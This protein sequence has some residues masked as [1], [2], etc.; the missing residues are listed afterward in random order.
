MGKAPPLFT[1]QVPAEIVERDEFNS[2]RTLRVSGEECSAPA[3]SLLQ[4]R[5]LGISGIWLEARSTHAAFAF[6][7]KAISVQWPFSGKNAAV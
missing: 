7:A 2:S 4:L 1:G 3:P 5:R 6:E